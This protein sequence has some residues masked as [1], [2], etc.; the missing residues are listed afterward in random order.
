MRVYEETRIVVPRD[1]EGLKYFGQLV[2]KYY[3][4]DIDFHIKDNSK[5]III[6]F[7]KETEVKV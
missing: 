6:E 3:Q 7:T 5:H 1:K 4:Q 2:E